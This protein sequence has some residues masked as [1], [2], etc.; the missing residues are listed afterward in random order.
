MKKVIFDEVIKDCRKKYFHSFQYRCVDD[1]KFTNTTNHEKIIY[2][3]LVLDMWN[4]NL[5]FM[6]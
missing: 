3:H 6:G 1:I 4:L 5:N 2:P